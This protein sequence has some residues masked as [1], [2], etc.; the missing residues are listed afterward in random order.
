MIDTWNLLH[1]E[2][3]LSFMF[4]G[5]EG[6]TFGSICVQTKSLKMYVIDVCSKTVIS[7][8]DNNQLMLKSIFKDQSKRKE[9][10]P[11]YEGLKEFI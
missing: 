6:K 5:F 4:D 10:E 3:V 8:S 1:Q 9:N 2:E 11:Y 7:T